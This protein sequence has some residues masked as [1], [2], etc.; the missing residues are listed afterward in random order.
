MDVRR[1]DGLREADRHAAQTGQQRHS[2]TNE[3]QPDG[4]R[5]VG[6]TLCHCVEARSAVVA[7]AALVREHRAT[8][9]GPARDDQ[10]I[11]NE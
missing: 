6:L 10:G 2:Q 1:S 5:Q 7:L 8:L 11:A 4:A 3:S 9:L